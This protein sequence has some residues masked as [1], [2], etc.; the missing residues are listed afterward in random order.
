MRPNDRVKSLVRLLDKTVSL[1]N[2]M[3]LK[4]GFG[5]QDLNSLQR[6]SV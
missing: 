4:E 6:N 1:G 3:T 5:T 2:E